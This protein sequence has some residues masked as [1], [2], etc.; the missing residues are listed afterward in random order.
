[1]K[2]PATQHIRDL[3]ERIVRINAAEEWSDEL[4]PTQLTALSYLVQ[5]NRFSRS[6]SQVAEFLATTRGTV[7]QTLKVLARKGLIEKILSQADRRW[8][9]YEVTKAGLSALNR[10]TVIDE[11]L[12]GLNTQ[13]TNALAIGLEALVRD[14]LKA[15][16]RRRFGVCKTCRY[17]K[18]KGTGGFCTL[19]REEL[20]KKDAE[21]ICHEYQDAA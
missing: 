18:P 1:M 4:S 9:S 6:P 13:T 14:A 19:L 5:A 12:E 2:Q 8:A 7:S 16:G 10:S 20:T 3:L 17:Y 11:V 21:Q 15:R